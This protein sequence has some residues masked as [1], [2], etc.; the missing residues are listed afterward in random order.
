M[1][2]S[3]KQATQ[4]QIFSAILA[5]CVIIGATGFAWFWIQKQSA[6]PEES[7]T[8]T[9]AVAEQIIPPTPTPTPTKLIHG[10][11]TYSVSGGGGAGPAIS[12]I[13]FDPLDPAV[14]GTQVI[15][16]KGSDISGVSSIQVNVRT[17]TKTTTVALKRINGTDLG[18]A[19]EGTWTV[20]ETYLYNYIPTIV[21]KSASGQTN[22]PVTIRE[23]K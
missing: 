9:P 21:A 3:A 11:E 22:I 23:R 12:E 6:I 7:Q 19:W 2:S 14:G 10:K 13:T 4:G 15:T 1:K 18:G 8:Q 5:I 16:V 17:D 20:P